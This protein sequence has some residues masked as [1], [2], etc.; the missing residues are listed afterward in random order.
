MSKN[1]TLAVDEDILKQAR[2]VAAKRQKSLSALVREYLEHLAK[3]TTA[4]DKARQA[5][6]KLIDETDADMGQARPVREDA[7]DR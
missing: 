2:I 1:I 6:L 4:K 5:L 3:E 7:Y